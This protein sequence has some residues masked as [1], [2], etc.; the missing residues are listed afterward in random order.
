L[1]E[2]QVVERR[3]REVI[4]LVERTLFVPRSTSHGNEPPVI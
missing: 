2:P 4:D 3:K 1:L